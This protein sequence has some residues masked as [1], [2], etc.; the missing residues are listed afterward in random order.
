MVEEQKNNEKKDRK[1]K[2]L[3]KMKPMYHMLKTKKKWNV[4]RIFVIK[5]KDLMIRSNY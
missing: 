2:V 1:E 4:H 3:E 5:K